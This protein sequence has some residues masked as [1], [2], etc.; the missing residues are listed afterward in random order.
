MTNQA[1]IDKLIEM[2]LTSMVDAFRVQEE[3][4]S[5]KEISFEDRF[6]LLVDMEYT[7]RKNN[8]LKRL[9]K[10]AE[11]DQPSVSVANIDYT[12]GC[13]LNRDRVKRLA[14]CEYIADYR[15]IFI[16]GATESSKSCITGAFGMKLANVTTIPNIFACRIC[17][18]I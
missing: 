14:S 6:G 7:N 8:R 12:L 10:Y 1:T 3:V 17:S 5:M 13:N 15:N 9:I 11:F 18:S 16:I 2:R 4:L